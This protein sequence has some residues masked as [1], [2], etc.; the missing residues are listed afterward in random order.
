GGSG[1]MSSQVFTYD[2]AQNLTSNA[3]TRDGYI[4]LGWSEDM[5]ATTAT[6]TDGQSVN[7]LRS[8]DQTSVTFYAVWE[9]ID[10]TIAVTGGTADK[11]TAIIGEMITLTPEVRTGYTFQGWTTTPTLSIAT[12]KFTMP[13][14][15]VTAL[16]EFTANKY[17]ITYAANGGSGTMSSQVFTYDEAQNLTTN[18]FTRDGYI[19]LGW[20]EDMTATTAT[21]TDGQ[22]IN[23]LRSADQS[24]VTFYAVWEAIDYNITVTGGTADKTTAII[25]EMI[26]L[27]PET[28]TGYTFQ[29]WTTTPT[30]TIATNKFTM[31]ALNVT[32]VA[33]FTANKYTITYAANG[34]SG[35][36][37]SQVFT[38]DE[39]QNLTS[40]AFTRDG[41]IFL[42]W[43]ED[44]T[45]TTATY[46]DAQSVNNLRSADQSSVTFY[47]VWEAVDYTITVNDG[48]A[49]KYTAHIGESV[50]LSAEPNTGYT[51][52]GWT[53]V[54]EAG[55]A[56]TLSGNSFVMPAA[57][58][59]ATASYAAVNYTVTVVDG[60]ADF[61]TA[62]YQQ[63]VT[64][65]HTTKDGYNFSGWTIV[66][67]NGNAIAVSGSTFSMPAAD[68]TATANF[69]AI[70]YVIT[71]DNGTADKATANIGAEVILTANTPE[72][73]YEFSS[74]TI[75]EGTGASLANENSN[76][77]TLTVGTS[78]INVRANFTLV[79]YIVTIN[80][81]TA[82]K[83]TAT[84]GETVTITA[85]DAA[86]GYEFD[87]W[88][89]ESGT[90]ATLADE[91]SAATTLVIGTENVTV[92]ANYK[93]TEFTITV[94]GGTANFTT[95]T[96]ETVV[97]LT[98]DAKPG[99]KFTGWTTE[100]NVAVTFTNTFVMPASDIDVTANFVANTYTIEYVNNGGIG[101]T[102]DQ[103]ATYDQDV[104]IL[105]N[106]KFTKAG[107]EFIRW[108]T[109]ADGS[110]DTY[111]P[112]STQRNLATEGTVT[113]YAQWDIAGFIIT[114]DNN[115]GKGSM[116]TQQI[117]Y[118]Q[119]DYLTKCTFT[120]TGYRFMG[121]NLK[122]DGTG[123]SYADGE[124]VS[125]ITA[126]EAVTLYAQWAPSEYYVSYEPNATD[127]EG[128]MQKQRFYFN[129]SAPLTANS[130][131]RPGFHFDGWNRNAEG[132][133]AA[134]ADGE[135]V[136]NVSSVDGDTVSLFAQW[137]A[138]TY[139]ITF[140]ANDGS[141]TMNKEVMTYGIEAPLTANA[142]TREG[143]EF[144]G[145][146]TS[147]DGSVV[148]VNMQ[149]V[150]NLSSTYGGNV[151]LYAVWT[152]NAYI[153][154]F[155][156][157]GCESGTM[158][159][160]VFY[161][162]VAQNLNTYAY[163]NTGY[164][165][166][167][168]A[169]SSEGEV[170]Y[171]DGQNVKNLTTTPGTTVTLY[172]VWSANNYTITF[173]ANSASAT[174]SMTPQ[175]VTYN[176]AV[177]LTANRYVLD[178]YAFIA[179]NTA[180]DG[181]GTTYLDGELVSNLSSVD[182]GNV[183]LYA[184]WQ[185]GEYTISTVNCTATSETASI[186]EVITIIPITK[187][188]YT[189]TGWVTN[190]AE[191]TI[192]ADYKFT[193]PATDVSIR[194]T[195][196]PIYYTITYELNGGENSEFNPDSICVLDE[197]QL[198]DPTRSHYSFIGW[199]DENDNEVTYIPKGSIGNIKLTA[200]WVADVN[201]DCDGNGTA[202]VNIDDD[203]DYIPDRNID[204]DGD[205]VPDI[206][207][208]NDGDYFCDE[209]CDNIENTYLRFSIDNSFETCEY[210]GS[211]V[212]TNNAPS[213]QK[214]RYNAQGQAIDVLS[215]VEY[216]WSIN[217]V[218]V[219]DQHGNTFTMP[220][221]ESVSYEIPDYGV[222]EVIAS[223]M[224]HSVK[225][226]INYTVRHRFICVMWDDVI[227]VINT[228]EY[229]GG[230]LFEPDR[231]EW[232]HNGELIQGA[233]NPFFSED[234]GLTGNYYVVAYTTDGEQFTS[235]VKDC[236]EL[237]AVSLVA[238]PNP[239]AGLVNIKGGTW[240]VGDAITVTN[241]AGQTVITQQAESATRDK[242]D[243]SGLPQ[244]TYVIK[245]GNDVVS[246]IKR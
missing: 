13:A 214:T 42:G 176:N 85:A 140:L 31:P 89:I 117:N 110:G 127:A 57:N 225:Y 177:N 216:K 173:D 222:I 38:Y 146:A 19:F 115:G 73:G 76:P 122:A 223:L 101:T 139:T 185:I 217:G 69:T 150:V 68:V 154:R 167:G 14:S 158:D 129:V 165:F 224:G 197:V 188:G 198:S 152:S 65:S 230:R 114:F 128:T 151:N 64:L 66:D 138:N 237:T 25:G 5:T 93:L 58:V 241:S 97:N 162:G 34:G 234:G 203:G 192:S 210:E 137:S 184:Q 111:Y 99:Y 218:A 141:G 175:V 124:Y 147:A 131:K 228:G 96:Y 105:S 211:I 53:V 15:N 221:P 174:G 142:Y 244:G 40:N 209:N 120:K 240:N 94:D 226:S 143:Y 78:D 46:T 100:P 235:C 67:A 104:T 149:N 135:M 200:I 153:V 103:D 123:K 95:A 9:A 195:Y 70:D 102:V 17:T 71:V 166:K 11:T 156:G 54:T 231:Y 136:E 187:E 190:P 6:Y 207:I 80:N 202:D 204:V 24:S 118:D 60:T 157:N 159:D 144:A 133:S 32:A 205:C 10:Y 36:M 119:W 27:T 112:G 75:T 83:A 148:Y 229:T 194:A 62:I 12:N 52:T 33:E 242:I 16:A 72:A 55:D 88:T 189:W 26:T 22:S 3:F 126:G 169:T 206:F 168:W 121:W 178:G 81:G 37:S 49:D 91:K 92:A 172:A 220:K 164:T 4:F 238:F 28:R 77:A 243:L 212:L 50:A 86:Y 29:G 30:L 181:S 125:N 44:M 61:E 232:Y 116:A 63:T 233:T 191:L 74:W 39:T 109:A 180:A 23:N 20:S 245:I 132:T 201:L 84:K 213:A 182:Y 219:D 43:S 21:Y 161:Y 155:D 171:K 130:F 107:Y 208:D 160:Q 98:P 145:W 7:N 113:L 246:V 134:Y 90:G 41:Y 87:H 170:V 2:E 59:I 45:A 56:I 48:E 163:K 227:S 179:W 108:N 1:T 193:M 79:N 106:N 196:E 8:T 35:T 236:S 215:Y 186:G 199:Y 51:F 47:A 183:T 18:A 82:D 239:S